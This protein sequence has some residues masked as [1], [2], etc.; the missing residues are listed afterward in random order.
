VPGNL[1]RWVVL[2]TGLVAAV[3]AAVIYLGG[4]TSNPPLPASTFA[5]P[6]RLSVPTAGNGLLQYGG[7]WGPAA[8]YRPYSYLLVSP[9]H[10]A[11]AAEAPGRSL[12]YFAGTDVNTKWSTGVSYAQAAR[13][14]WLLEDSDGNLLVNRGYPDNYVGDVGNPDYQRAWLANVTAF[15]R[16]HHDDGVIIDDVLYDLRPLAGTESAK[17]PTQQAW[18]DA[19]LSFVKTVGSALKARGYYVLV[20]ASGYVP[21]D[22]ASDDGTNTI[23]WWTRLAPY[24]DGLMNEFYEQTPDGTN[25]VRSDGNAW[26]QQ[27]AGWERLVTAAQSMGKD[28]V[29]LSYG[30][31]DD[32]AQM[33]YGKASFLLAWNGRGGAF[34]YDPPAED[35]VPARHAWTAAIGQ[36]AA[37]MQRVGSG[38]LRRYTGGVAIVN[39]DPGTSQQFDLGGRYLMPDGKAV[40]SVTLSP[41]S[42]LVLPAAPQR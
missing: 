25:A 20:N 9:S 22:V 37:A 11:R 3:A 40:T 18:S 32:L 10:A 16:T 28:F 36:P 35:V 42:G 5:P 6:A 15:L 41:T 31:A 23:R 7:Q 27:W 4:Q 8:S 26:N 29:G 19:Q 24:V 14:H 21:D 1:R 2:L 30:P 38:W 12:V 34:I 33:M 17:Y 13:N 39:P